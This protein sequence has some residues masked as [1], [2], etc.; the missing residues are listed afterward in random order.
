MLPLAAA[1]DLSAFLPTHQRLLQ[2]CFI[3]AAS[4]GDGMIRRD[5][6]SFFCD[7]LI[8]LKSISI[9]ACRV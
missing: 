1:H 6:Q 5:P 8:S 7:S 3:P 9:A 4:R 2:V